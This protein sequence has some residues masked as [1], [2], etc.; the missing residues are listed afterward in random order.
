MQ[1]LSP[2][3]STR[4]QSGRL[5]IHVL[6][7]LL[8]PLVLTGCDSSDDDSAERFFGIEIEGRIQPGDRLVG[9]LSTTDN[10]LSDIGE[11][12]TGPI[13][14]EHDGYID[15]YLMEVD[16]GERL[17]SMTSGSIDTFLRITD[18]DGNIIEIDDD[19]G[20]GSHAFIQ[21]TFPAGRYLIIASS[22]E[23]GETGPYNLNLV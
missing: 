22:F 18:V 15:I 9:A 21:R 12:I 6:L 17:I 19:D 2:S 7:I 13:P 4:C 20:T 14:P 10:R 16:A 11:S 3:E 23:S 1:H 5:T 8:V